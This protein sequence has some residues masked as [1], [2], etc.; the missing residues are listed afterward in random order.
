MGAIDDVD[1]RSDDICYLRRRRAALLR[2]GAPPDGK[3]PLMSRELAYAGHDGVE[4][5][6]MRGLPIG[7]VPLSLGLLVVD[8][9]TYDEKN[10]KFAK[11]WLAK[12]PPPL[13]DIP[14]PSGGRHLYYCLP[15]P[16]HINLGLRNSGL[17]DR[18]RWRYGDVLCAG[19]HVLLYDVRALVESL[20]AENLPRLTSL[21]RQIY[22]HLPDLRDG[23]YPNMETLQ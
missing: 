18:K 7:L 12:L 21:E 10:R 8:V 3:N 14:T 16:T 23:D 4:G 20:Q 15:G 2:C 13:A 22:Q 6:Y 11:H 9:D 17:F 1:Q 19:S 5:H